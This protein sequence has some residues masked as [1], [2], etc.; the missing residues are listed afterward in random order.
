MLI[1]L[2]V[3]VYIAIMAAIGIN[4]YRKA[5]SLTQFVVGGRSAGPWTSAFAYGT[6]Y[7]SAVLFIG[8]AGRSG[9]DYGLW[10]MLVGVG[11]AFLG[12]YLAWKILGSRTR[13]V[14]KRLKIK[15]MP[16]FFEQRYDSR[17]LKTI[18]AIIIF[19]FMTPYSASVYSGLSYL[20]EIVLNVDYHIAMLVI[21]I[22]AAAYVVLGGYLASLSADL[23]QGVV[24]IAGVIAMLFTVSNAPEVGGFSNG[25]SSVWAIMQDKGIADFQSIPLSGLI[26]L[27]LLTSLGTWGLPQMVHKFYGV[28]DE[29][30]I[31]AGT[32]ISTFFCAIISIGAY[33]IGSLTRLFFT[34]VP[35]L[36]NGTKS[37]DI[38]IPQI[39]NGVLPE[40][41][42]GVV[43]V[44]VLAASVSTLSSITL[45]SCSTFSMDLIAASMKKDMDK[46]QTL[47]LTRILCLI[48]IIGSYFIA[49]FKSP[50]LTLMSFSWGSV[51]GSFLA[52]YLLG[53]YFKQINK[54]GAFAG[55][56]GGLSTSVI[57]AVISK[58]NSGK[59]PLFGITAMLVSFVLCIAVSLIAS[60]LK[61]ANSAVNEKFFD[62][63][64]AVK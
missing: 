23:I 3:A 43:L 29:R 1:W 62:K 6:A 35:K 38:M 37:Y 60:R 7:F 16:Q 11:N 8:Y 49:S 59:A 54:A 24:M 13:E 36:S 28:A 52:P 61:S 2:I 5:S 57:L 55:M 56:L 42:L 32:V 39:L 9:Y 34:D 25:I 19:I 44:L 58:F 40:F 10:A 53:L 48:F 17:L 45:T 4:S 51:A 15:T 41:L 64:Y 30:G 14:T 33:Y 46:K 20:C 21:A 63:E 26:S 27:I 12:G 50:I 47:L 22:V 31:R 18:A